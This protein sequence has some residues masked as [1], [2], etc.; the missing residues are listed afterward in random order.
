[1]G[2]PALEVR[3]WSADDV[4]ALP[5]DPRNRYETV[6]GVLLVSPSPAIR[7]QYF[8]TEL[9]IAIGMYLKEQRVAVVVSA[10]SDVEL[11]P[12][13]LMQPD[14]YSM[15]LI[16]G[17]RPQE[18]DGNVT[19]LLSVEILSPS[20]SRHDRLIKR[21]RLQRAAIECWLVDLDARLVERWTPDADRPEI[22]IERLT[23]MPP[24]ATAP[25]E[26]ALQPLF[27]DVLGSP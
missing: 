8:Q 14:V 12:F 19:P 7:H 25:F 6:D 3:R 15:P 21:P 10:P 22:V 5:D 9:L 17:R 26:L 24:G 13:T 11:D 2:M 1:M 4:R 18:T 20:T 16:D 27:A 23:W